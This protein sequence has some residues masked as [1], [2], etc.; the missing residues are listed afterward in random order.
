MIQLT[1][2]NVFLFLLLVLSAYTLGLG[3]VLGRDKGEDKKYD[4]GKVSSLKNGLLY[5]GIAGLVLSIGIIVFFVSRDHKKNKEVV[6]QFKAQ[7]REQNPTVS[8][9]YN[10]GS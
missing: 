3:I 8:S 7:Y 10:R 1:F 2:R 6:D 9:L 5:S 4:E